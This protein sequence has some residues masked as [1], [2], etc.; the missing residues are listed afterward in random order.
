MRYKLGGLTIVALALGLALAAPNTARSDEA[1]PR[2]VEVQ[3]PAGF[4]YPNGIA[5]T[6]DG[7]LF[8]GLVTSGQ[9]LRRSST[10]EWS[11][12]FSG[13][14]EIYA[15]TSLRLDEDRGILWGASPD[16]LPGDQARPHRLFALD[17]T[18]GEVLRILTLPDGGFGNDLAL[19]PDGSVYVT[20]SRNGRVLRLRP[21]A[22]LLEVVAE[23]PGLAP[24][25]GVGVGGIARAADGRLIVGNF[26]SGRL[27]IVEKNGAGAMG[28]RPLFLPRRLEN[29]DGLAF[30]PDG[31]LLVLEGAVESGDG[32]LLRV[33]APFA[34]GMRSLEVVQAGLP[35]PVNLT[36]A[37]D[38]RAFVTLSRIRHRLLAGRENDVPGSFSVLIVDTVPPPTP[39]TE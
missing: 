5:R 17:S 13:S 23:H 26:G 30:A 6:P 22:E 3:L 34:S 27:Y 2:A 35:S 8:V 39:G 18:T 4:L 24:M 12:F 29:P 38:G 10:G 9:V 36:V 33:P 11:V 37:P 15:G 20:D 28:V 25:N 21:E 31:A 32:K 14:E 7:T 19:A 16:F 1:S